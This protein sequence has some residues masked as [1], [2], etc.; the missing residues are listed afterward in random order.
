MYKLAPVVHC[1][2]P[3]TTGRVAQVDDRTERCGRRIGVWNKAFR[4]GGGDVTI[5]RLLP[6]NENFRSLAGIAAGGQ[7]PEPWV[8]SGDDAGHVVAVEL[9]GG[10]DPINL[11]PQVQYCTET[12]V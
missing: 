11:F 3:C 2:H 12:A 1:E 5:P 4:N 6:L 10:N 8:S 7:A 9:G